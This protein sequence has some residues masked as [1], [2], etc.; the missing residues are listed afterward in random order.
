[1]KTQRRQ[2]IC[3]VFWSTWTNGSE[4]LARRTSNLRIEAMCVAG[5]E[6]ENI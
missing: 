3:A 4:V 6:Y 5:D 1:M 2:R